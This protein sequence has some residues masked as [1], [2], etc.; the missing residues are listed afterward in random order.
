[1]DS[2]QKPHRLGRH[3]A[4][5]FSQFPAKDVQKMVYQQGESAARSRN[6]GTWMLK[7]LR[8]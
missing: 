6:G 1:M 4:E 5:R 7:T 8:R 2:A 3:L